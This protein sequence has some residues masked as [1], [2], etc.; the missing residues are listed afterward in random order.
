MRRPTRRKHGI[1]LALGLAATALTL[2]VTPLAG[3]ADSPPPG[4]S[5]GNQ[6]APTTV[7]ATT[8]RAKAIGQC[9]KSVATVMV[10]KRKKCKGTRAQKNACLIKV[11]REEALAKRQCD[12]LTVPS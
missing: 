8:S 9:K 10:A 2:A 3:A 1:G 12:K 4:T 6:Y 11:Q 5:A 7:V